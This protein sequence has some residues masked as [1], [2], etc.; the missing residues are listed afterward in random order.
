MRIGLGLVLGCSLLLS[1]PALA[2]EVATVNG[3]KITD[4]EFMEEIEQLGPQGEM[5]KS[6]PEARVGFLN[7]MITLRL[8]EEAGRKA[9]IEKS[10]EY[11]QRLDMVKRQVLASVYLEKTVADKTTD[12]EMKK[13]FE[14]N[15]GEFSDK[16]VCA[17]HI[18][19]KEDKQKEAEKILA[20]AKKPKAD[21][22]E[23]AKKHSTGPSG[24]KGGDLGCFG[25]G[26]MVK[27]F[28]EAAFG[29]KANTVHPK[30]VKT[31][32]GYHIIK[33]GEV[34]GGD[35]VKFADVKEKVEREM[36]QKVRNDLVDGVRN[37]AKISVNEKVVKELKLN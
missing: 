29:T 33:V 28:E 31:R 32:F 3:K 34:K 21:F 15:K 23:L 30:L 6:Q 25:K 24:P 9:G 13:Y 11:K 26:R 14:A 37:S 17:A 16:E 5:L 19:L 2:A 4:K 10:A 8:L 35:K 22:G 27:E 1:A 18:L 20:E 12:K 7:Q 36:R